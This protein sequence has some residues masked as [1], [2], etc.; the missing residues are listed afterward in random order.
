[1]PE[2][3]VGEGLRKAAQTSLDISVTV[4]QFKPDISS[5]HLNDPCIISK[6]V[7]VTD[8]VGICCVSAQ[9]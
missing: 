4:N 8:T 1:M 2:W 9:V 3:N 5:L 6:N 7:T